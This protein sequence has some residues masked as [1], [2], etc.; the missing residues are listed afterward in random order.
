MNPQ[1]LNSYSYGLGNPITNKD[2][3]GEIVPLLLAGWAAIEIGLSAYDAYNAYQTVN[4][5]NASSLEK[6][7]SVT[8]FVAGLAAP[9]GG[10]G[11]VGR[12]IVG[13]SFGKLGT[14]VDNAA[15]KI[16][17]FTEHGLNQTINR[18]VSPTMLLNTTKNPT[19]VLQ[20]AGGNKLYLTNQ[21]GVVL[22]KNGQVVTTYTSKQFEPHVQNVLKQAASAEKKK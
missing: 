6:S 15:G 8:G 12:S 1:A 7:V 19:V 3:E 9:G 14:V 21:A 17:G 4:D 20:Q 16:T 11:T 2:P 10:Y 13:Q 22:N 5:P 18:G